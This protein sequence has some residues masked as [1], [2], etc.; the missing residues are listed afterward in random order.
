MRFQ[1][2]FSVKAWLEAGASPALCVTLRFTRARRGSEHF[3]AYLLYRAPYRAEGLHEIT[4]EQLL[5]NRENAGN[6]IRETDLTCLLPHVRVM[7]QLE[8]YK[9]LKWLMPYLP[10]IQ[11]PAAW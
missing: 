8:A 3:R 6:T 4:V 5:E 7:H 9:E 10:D 1:N 2:L 11:T